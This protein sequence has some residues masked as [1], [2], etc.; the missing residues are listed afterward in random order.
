M[1]IEPYFLILAVVGLSVV[2]MAFLP[3]VGEKL[4]ISYTIPLLLF[5]MILY[6][7]GIPITWPDPLW[8]WEWTK[9][10]TEL[11][12]VISLMGAGLKIGHRY[13][14]NDWKKPFRLVLITMP[15]FMILVFGIAHFVLG[16]NMALS[17]LLAAVLAPTDPV[18]ASELQLEKHQDM[19]EKNTGLRFTLTG[20][21]GIN[22]G[23]AFPF[24]YLAILLSKIDTGVPFDWWEWSWFYVAYKLAG[25]ILIG[26]LIGWL[27]STA[28]KQLD[29]ERQ[30][31]ILNGFV[32]VA[33]TLFSYG[34]AEIALTYGFMSVFFTGIFIQYY[35]TKKDEDPH[36]DSN[37]MLLFVSESEKLLIVLW[38]ILFG[39]AIMSGLLGLVG[40]IEALIALGIV[41][42]IRP[43]FGYIALF[44]TDL[45]KHKRMAIGFFGI[46]GIGTLF[47]LSYAYLNGNF[48]FNEQVVGIVSYVLL[49]SIL[50]HGLTSP[51]VI[52]YFKNK[53]ETKD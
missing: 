39:G 48:N 44:G 45:G 20:E 37:K 18:L 40:W 33:L 42:I 31:E 29:K 5:G 22:D 1:T 38:T 19:H 24:V 26:S 2:L 6:S 21:A 53:N 13:T 50:I 8:P 27:F 41:L 16:L 17:V 28:L 25:G 36:P 11:V 15:L 46:K 4:R 32:A 12:V 47:Y 3:I 10:L 30:N 9:I 35:R 52:A 34:V 7:V 49:F 51:S 23:L 14:W 43:L